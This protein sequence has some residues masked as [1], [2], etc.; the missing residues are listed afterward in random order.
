[1]PERKFA[2]WQKTTG[3][4]S[5]PTCTEYY[6]AF[7]I[8]GLVMNRSSLDPKGSDLPPWI[9]VIYE[10][11]QKTRFNTEKEAQDFVEEKLKEYVRLA[12][13]RLGLIR[14]GHAAD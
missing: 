10:K 6:L 14:D 3:P 1:M 13:T 9:A 5:S 2:V 8:H 12:A 7:G 11:R 4:L